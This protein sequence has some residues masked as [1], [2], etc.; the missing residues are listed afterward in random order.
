MD[1]LSKLYFG[2]IFPAQQIK[3]KDPEYRRI[4]AEIS[5][6]EEKLKE[7]LP[8]QYHKDLEEIDELFC[9]AGEL[10]AIEAFSYGVSLGLQLMA[11][12]GELDFKLRR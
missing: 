12:A 8:T 9:A 11:R 2:L 3:P 1:I 4:H 7:A 10:Y 6:L 5:R